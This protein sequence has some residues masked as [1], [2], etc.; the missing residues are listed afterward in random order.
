MKKL[1][2]ILLVLTFVFS[3]CTVTASAEENIRVIIDIKNVKFD[4]PPT[5][6][7]GRT[8]VP[9]RAIFEALGATVE[10]DDATQTVTS[11]K[12]DT[13]I[14]L[15]INSNIMTVNG[16]EKTL[17]VPATLIDSRTLVP[18]RFVSEALGC[19]VDW[20]GENNLVK[21]TK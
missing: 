4:V 9:L 18:L 3:L 21:I 1:L 7:N 12:G 8:L 17:D 20:D 15:T 13:K 5:I 14:S 16:E 2:S 6:I 10:W 19:K 11:E